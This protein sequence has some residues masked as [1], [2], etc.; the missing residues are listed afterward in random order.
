MSN[1]PAE[2]PKYNFTKGKPFNKKKTTN[3]AKKSYKNIMPESLQT[4]IYLMIVES[5]S[6]CKKIEEYL[7]PKYTCIS[8]KG[9]IR[10]IENGLKSID[11][12]NEG[13]DSCKIAFEISKEKK[14]HVEW[15]REIIG[16][17][18]KEN[19]ILASDDDR[20]GEAIAWH[21]CQ[22]FDLDI[23]T[24]QRAIF[25]EITQSAIKKALEATTVINMNIV[26]AQLC[27]Q[28]LDV[29][30]GYK[31]S[32]VLWKHIYRDNNNSLSAGRCQTPA[33][34][35][36]FD[37]EMESRASVPSY[38][39][40][41]T[42][43]FFPKKI[44]FDLSADFDSDVEV[45][46]FLELSK[47]FKHELSIGKRKESVRTSPKPF[48]T[49]GLLQ[50]ASSTLSIGPKETMS[51][52]QQLYQDGLITYMRTESQKYSDVFLDT[53]SKYIIDRFGSP[54]YIGN[55]D[56]I[57][58]LDSTNP[59]EAIRVTNMA[60][61]SIVCENPRQNTLYKLIWR[62]TVESCM[63]NA[64][65]N[66][67]TVLITA[68]L[69]RSYKHIVEVPIFW[70]YMKL[71][72]ETRVSTVDEQSRG[73]ALLLYI[74]SSYIGKCVTPFRI[75]DA[76]SNRS[77]PFI[78]APSSE[79][80]GGILNENWCKYNAITSTLSIHG[81]HSH[82]TEASLIKKLEDLGIG[83]PST[84]AMIVD[85]IIE[86]GYVNKADIEGITIKSV[87]YGLIDGVITKEE[88]DRTFGKETG[89]LVIQPSGLLV[90]DF[91]NAH[92]CSLFSY[93]Y[94]KKMECILDEISR[95]NHI[96]NPWA[97]C[98]TCSAEIS[99]LL[100]PLTTFG[101]QVFNI[102][103]NDEY[104]FVFEKYGP[105]LRKVLADGT[106]EYKSVKKG[107]KFDLDKLKRGEYHIDEL[108]HVNAN[109]QIGEY[110]AIPIYLKTGPFGLYIEYG[111]KK[112]SLESMG[113][114]YP[115]D[116]SD[117]VS[118]FDK[119]LEIFVKRDESAEKSDS[120]I[121]RTLTN[122]ISIRNGKYGAYIHY[123]PASSTK[124]KFF[125]IQKFKESYRHCS[126]EVILNWIK[127]K[128]NI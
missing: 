51:I 7:G 81:K 29:L 116:P 1:A 30:V 126:E 83:R 62:N 101:K 91:L 42:G 97:I 49:S 111:E 52:C 92:F 122:E 10:N 85:T 94:T 24:T 28:V 36:V 65:F 55:R 68:P 107:L 53:A 18:K 45:L 59:H 39:Y 118:I 71:A 105:V 32:P 66:N 95:G 103:G 6:K 106:Y 20:E 108:I 13:K 33:L 22:T 25:H 9:H 14:D 121:I 12:K 93:D 37:N 123:L 69:D 21:I 50:K 31:I 125:N 73:A 48:N 120:K 35:L 112:E 110:G 104:K 19:I 43:S 79:A 78:S 117:S 89:K 2:K 109:T 82:Y 113:I 98:Q 72:E 86:R 34:R 38:T 75:E 47:E 23:A 57:V 58:N 127:E 115:L 27:R 77:N 60:L 80:E 61:D 5:P 90:S 124:P 8:S 54:D 102:T 16:R 70:G 4:S 40:R 87:E 119:V 100:K 64:R 3:Y 76:K 46:Q 17:F 99:G 67:T 96:S 74:Q 84:Y 15:M 26:N 41:I 114:I 63:E 128:Y 88:I 44:M 11:M 56:N